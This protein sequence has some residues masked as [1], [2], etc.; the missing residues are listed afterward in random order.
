MIYLVKGNDFDMSVSLSTRDPETKVDT[1]I[2]LTGA[3]KLRLAL[4]GHGMHVFA[5]DV[6]VRDNS[7]NTVQGM[8]PGRSLLDGDY[9]LEVTFRKDDKDK[10]FYVETDAEGQPLF[11]AVDRIESDSDDQ[12]EGEG[13]GIALSITVQPETIDFSGAQ[14]PAGKSAYQSWLDDGNEG[15]E[16]D[17][18][19]SLVGPQGP[20]GDKGDKGNKGDPG[21]TGAAGAVGKSAYQSWLDQGNEGSEAD[22]IASLK[23]ATGEQGPQGETGA[24]GDKG[25]TGAT[26]PQGP[27]GPQGNPGSSVDYPFELEND[28]TV[29]GTTKAATAESVKTVHNEVSQ[30]GLIV[31]GGEISEILPEGVATQGCYSNANNGK[32]MSSSSGAALMTFPCIAGDKYVIH[33]PKSNNSAGFFLAYADSSPVAVGNV[34]NGVAGCIGTS[35]EVNYTIDEAANHSYIVVGYTYASGSPTV[36]HYYIDD[37]G[38][39]TQVEDVKADLYTRLQKEVSWVEGLLAMGGVFRTRSGKK[40]SLPIL[41][42]AGETVHIT[43]TGDTGYAMTPIVQVSGPEAKVANSYPNTVLVTRV[44]NNSN[45]YQFTASEDIYISICG[46]DDCTYSFDTLPVSKIDILEEEVKVTSPKLRSMNVLAFG[47]SGIANSTAGVVGFMQLVADSAALP[48]RAFVY[49]SNDGNTAD[50]VVNYPTVTNYAKDGTCL[51]TISGRSDSVLERVKRHVLESTDVNYV[52]VM[53]PANDAAAAHRNIGVMSE[54]YTATYDTETQ[55]GALEELCRYVTELG[56][57]IRFGCIIPWRI[58]WVDNDFYNAYI[59]VLQKWGVPY[60][61]LRSCAG[62]DIKD[63]AAHRNLYSLT[64][65]NYSSW[66][67]ATA[68]NLDDKVKYGG[69]LYKC[70]SDGVVG[71]VPTDS[72]YWMQVASGSADGTHLNSIGNEIIL[73]KVLAFIESL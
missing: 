39:V 56:K 48:Y 45:P 35:A 57:P 55:L 19:D 46:S 25:D 53:F 66:N 69:I 4:V 23:G 65:E 58:S 24:K 32:V 22:F 18:L 52:V 28:P 30:L 21:A 64:S 54:S 40:C 50:V 12:A 3:T 17:F 51:R 26:G 63:C 8:I 42:K 31:N 70:L 6:K 10:R 41:L 67:S 73:G 68:Y 1:P 16:A 60:T 36:T 33:I 11:V 38:L 15:S 37:N 2:D 27:Q 61:D 59:P 29:G 72:T 62:F 49:D 47:A 5:E 44:N 43:T 9:A 71:V 7:A 34:L 13:G 14:G 20:K